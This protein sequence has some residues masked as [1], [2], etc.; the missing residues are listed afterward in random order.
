MNLSNLFIDE[1]GSADRKEKFS[2]QYI[3][4]GCMINNHLRNT[5][6]IKADQIKFKYWGRTNI[7]FHSREIGRKIGDF[8]I[9]ND[10]NILQN[11]Q[12][13]LL[14]FLSLGGYQL[15]FVV[16]DKDKSII[17]NWTAIKNYEEPANILI[18]NFI[19]S[20]LA[21]NSK[22]RLVIESATS[23]RDFIFLKITSNYLSNGIKG[24]N[25]S[26]DKVQ[27]ALTEISFVTKNNFDIEEQIADLLAYGAKL[28]FLKKKQAELNFYQKEIVKIMSKKLFKMNPATKDK[29]RK[30]YSL[31]ESFKIL[32]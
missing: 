5:L 20:L 24:L 14:S 3:L 13:D 7:V 9:L 21:N 25:I 17:D 11:F 1:L 18:K 12:K 26:Y 4:C 32:P 6:K 15:F 28:K 19:L 16:L 2:K 31:I 23:E 22:G 27:D 29:K 8:K 10:Q 30:F